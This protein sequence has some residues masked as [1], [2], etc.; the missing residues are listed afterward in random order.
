[1]ISCNFE[2]EKEIAEK[3]YVY[4]QDQWLILPHIYYYSF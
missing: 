3:V 1:M 4:R 2:L